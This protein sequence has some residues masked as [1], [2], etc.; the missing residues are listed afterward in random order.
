MC[1]RCFTVFERYGKLLRS[2]KENVEK[3]RDHLMK[4][5]LILTN[6]E[7]LNES[8]RTISEPPASKR[9][10]LCTNSTSPDVVVSHIHSLYYFVSLMYIHLD[11]HLL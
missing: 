1:Q 3:A 11:T 6:D 9:L 4:A 5:N 2:I 10:A 8:A 7:A